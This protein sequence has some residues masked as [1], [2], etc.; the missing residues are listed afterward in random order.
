MRE[1]RQG[2]SVTQVIFLVC[3]IYATQATYHVL[4]FWYYATQATMSGLR[5]QER[6]QPSHTHIMAYL[7][8]IMS[9]FSTCSIDAGATSVTSRHDLPA[10][11]SH[12]MV[13]HTIITSTHVMKSRKANSHLVYI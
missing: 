8:H 3:C 11:N 9:Y 4:L 13:T 10:G 2:T 1:Y 6:Q 7:A 12:G 5:W